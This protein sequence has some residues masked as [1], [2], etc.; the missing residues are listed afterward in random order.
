[1][2]FKMGEREEGE[3]AQARK[4]EGWEPGQEANGRREREEDGEGVEEGVAEE[5]GQQNAPGD[6]VDEQNSGGATG[7][8]RERDDCKRSREEDEQQPQER[9]Q[10]EEDGQRGSGRGESGEQ[11]AVRE[12][13]TVYGPH[14]VPGKWMR[15]VGTVKEMIEQQD[16]T[17]HVTRA[18]IVQWE[19]QRRGMRR[20]CRTQ[21]RDCRY[22]HKV[23]RWKYAG[24]WFQSKRRGNLRV[25]RCRRGGRTRSGSDN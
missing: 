6:R 2:R 10:Q 17:G 1:M 5:G 3:E 16:R 22:A 7:E 8:G 4:E 12:G 23:E 18:A 13:M 15:Y 14:K 9:Q 24:S 21:L 11:G 20:D 19:H 25:R